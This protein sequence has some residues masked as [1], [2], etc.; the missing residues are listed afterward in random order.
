MRRITCSIRAAF[1][2]AAFALPSSAMALQAPI[3]V[4]PTQPESVTVAAGRRYQAGTLHRWFAGSAYRDLWATP[5]RVPVFDWGTYAGGLHPTKL[6]GGMQT[7][8]LRFETAGGA[9][10]VFRLSDKSVLSTPEQVQGTPAVR[11]FQDEISALH[12]AAAAI[13]A[14]IVEASGI[15][16]PTAIL[17]VMGD[18]SALG[19]YRGD[20]ADRL[21][22][23]EEFPNVPKDGVGF[24]GTTKIID[25]PELLH[26]L[27]SDSRQHVDARGFLAARLTDF[28]INDN[29]RHPGNW[30]WARLEAGPKTQWEPI[31]RDRDHAFVSYDGVL[32]SVA[33][34]A[35]PSLVSLGNAP[36]VQ[37]L[38]EPRMLDARLL[39]GL[40]KP[41]WDSVARALQSRITDA[42]IDSAAQAMP[43]EYLASAPRLAA[44]LKKRRDALGNAAN[45]FYRLLA[46]RAEVHG[47]DASDRAV[48]N[49]VADDIVDV[50][51]ESEGKPFF[52]RR[53]HARE[54]A[55][56]LVYLHG[57][58]DTALVTG[59]V[60]RSI[61]IRV[62][63]GNG[64][65]TLIDSST[66]AGAKHVARLYDAGAVVGVS[67]G[68]DTMFD[69]RPWE[70]SYGVLTPPN[71]DDGTRYEP[72]VGLSFYRGMGVTPRIGLARSEYGFD[73]RPYASMVM[74]EGEYATKFQGA[75]VA[76]AVDERLESSPV[77]FM[78][79]ARMSDLQ[80]VHFSG[81]GNVTIDT[82]ESNPLFAV[83]QRQWLFHP[84]IALAFG[85]TTDIALGPVLQHSV[86][87][88][89]RSPYLS[90]ARPYGVGSFDQV[91]MQ[92]D[93]RYEWRDVRVGEEHTHH[94]VLAEIRG[95]YVP[96]ALDVRSA[97]EAAS[98]S[99]GA[100]ITLPIPAQPFLVVR[101]GGK[102]VYGDFPF[103]EAAT[104]G[105][106][107]SMRYMDTQYYAGDASLY[108]TSEL[109]IPLVRFNAL[110]PL[111]AGIMGLA[112]AGRV[113]LDGASP[114][115]WHSRAGG[116]IWFGRGDASPVVTLVRTTEKRRS[117]FQL[118]FGLN[119]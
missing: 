69:R 57:G 42:V 21:G 100:S 52:S 101:A 104:I 78:V 47:T 48:I 2:G 26:L 63:G 22:M 99:I 112:E 5:I 73:Q 67:Y 95:L 89:A 41:V 35:K 36:D 93:A 97:F 39:G 107:G 34:W 4:V 108:G 66:V 45:Q 114:G 37:G 16:H 27:N 14:L 56:I 31:A 19:K 71:A 109:R 61:P 86:S 103:Y 24:G 51:L 32:L 15:L 79:L 49:R 98:A 75:R 94:R 11:I 80:V 13:S 46:A 12:P 119:F 62:I 115:G 83:H 17:M 9:E 50:R 105:G 74:I 25:S 40:E 29:D 58:D 44:I 85:S 102:K 88:S 23:I 111:R 53:F 82:G 113:H 38:T 59:H 54:T 72:L 116:G 70:R 68:P 1:G 33:R 81:L 84:A 18:D 64:A 8:S 77:H 6:G 30:K 43:I 117:G 92:V 20:F 7:K 65:N 90:S 60:R 118:G 87:D 76:I 10:Y 91:G 96:A 28:L 110:M 3:V 55:E 106:D